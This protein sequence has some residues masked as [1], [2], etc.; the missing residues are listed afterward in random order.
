MDIRCPKC[1]R[2][3]TVGDELRGAVVEC[4]SC[5]II[6]EV[7]QS[8]TVGIYAENLPT[9][10]VRCPGCGMTHQVPGNAR[11]LEAECMVCKRSFRI[12]EGAAPAAAKPTFAPPGRAAAAAA[13]ASSKDTS[14]IRLNRAKKDVDSTFQPFM[15][16]PAAPP[17]T[18]PGPAPRPNLPRATGGPAAIPVAPPPAKNGPTG[19][20]SAAPGAGAAPTVARPAAPTVP[21]A[22]PPRPAAP[23]PSP[24]RTSTGPI[25]TKTGGLGTVRPETGQDLKMRAKAA[26]PDFKLDAD[27]EV[28][29]LREATT[30]AVPQARLLF[31]LPIG[32]LLLTGLLTGYLAHYTPNPPWPVVYGL[33]LA[34]VSALVW[35]PLAAV[36]LGSRRKKIGLLVTDKRIAM[37]SGKDNLSVNR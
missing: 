31:W 22:P 27:E 37:V 18:Q 19:P 12:P 3:Y 21:I 25:T 8:G 26:F 29:E 32:L 10:E 36:R 17:P 9:V 24:A 5:G 16:A 30:G 35:L 13:S 14:T 33:V 34:F 15:P 4:G 6:F 7:P 28:L 20:A 11:G 23:P 2:R 1:S